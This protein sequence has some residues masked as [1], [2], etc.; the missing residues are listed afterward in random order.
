MAETL[1]PDDERL[2]NRDQVA[3]RF[4]ITKRHLEA[5]AYNGGGPPFVKINRSV[6]YR[7]SDVRA[8]LDARLVESTAAPAPQDKRRGGR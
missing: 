3:E 1:H 7:P 6:R 5:L 8:W 2:L 4:G